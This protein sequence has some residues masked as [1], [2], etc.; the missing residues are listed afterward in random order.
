[1]SSRW[2]IRKHPEFVRNLIDCMVWNQGRVKDQRMYSMMVVALE[3]GLGVVKTDSEDIWNMDKT[4]NSIEKKEV[5]T[6]IKKIDDYYAHFL[7]LRKVKEKESAP[8]FP[9]K[10]SV[11]TRAGEEALKVVEK[12]VV[13]HYYSGDIRRLI[14]KYAP[15]YKKFAEDKNDSVEVALE[16][17]DA[18]EKGLLKN[19]PIGD[20]VSELMH[21]NIV[22][23]YPGGIV[24]KLAFIISVFGEDSDKKLDAVRYKPLDI[25]HDDKVEKAKKLLEENILNSAELIGLCDR[26]DVFL[27]WDNEKKEY[28]VKHKKRKGEESGAESRDGD[29]ELD[30]SKFEKREAP[31]RTD[32]RKVVLRKWAAVILDID[33][34]LNQTTLD[35][36]VYSYMG[37]SR[38]GDVIEV[39]DTVYIKTKEDITSGPKQDCIYKYG[40]FTKNY[41][42]GYVKIHKMADIGGKL[43]FVGEKTDGGNELVFDGK[44]VQTD[45]SIKNVSI[46]DIKEISGKLSYVLSEKKGEK[47]SEALCFGGLDQVFKL[48]VYESIKSPISYQGGYACIGTRKKPEPSSLKRVF[49][50]DV[51]VVNGEEQTLP[52]YVEE[53]IQLFDVGGELQILIRDTAGGYYFMTKEGHKRSDVCENLSNV[54]VVGGKLAYFVID[55]Q[56]DEIFMVW[57]DRRR[58]LNPSEGYSQV[59]N[60]NNKPYFETYDADQKCYFLLDF[61]ETKARFD[62][63]VNIETSEDTIFIGGMQGGKY[64]YYTHKQEKGEN[65]K[66]KEKKQKIDWEKIEKQNNTFLKSTYLT[67]WS[68]NETTQG[69]LPD[70]TP[71]LIPQSNLTFSDKLDTNKAEFGKYTL[72]EDT[73]SLNLESLTK[74]ELE[75]KTTFADIPQSFNGKPLHEVFDYVLKTYGN[76]HYIPG[77]EYWK[78]LSENP[79]KTPEKLKNTSE[80]VYFPGSA[81]RHSSGLWSV[82]SGHWYSAKLCRNGGWLGGAWD[83]ADRVA[84]LEKLPVD[85]R[86]ID[87]QLDTDSLNT[88]GEVEDI[89]DKVRQERSYELSLMNAI[90]HPTQDRLD[91]IFPLDKKEPFTSKTKRF[92][93]HSKKV[94]ST[95][96]DLFKTHPKHFFDTVSATKDE[97]ADWY[98]RKVLYSL[99]PEIAEHKRREEMMLG[100]GSFGADSFTSANAE[101]YLQKMQGEGVEDG[102]PGDEGNDKEVLRLREGAN[103]MIATG[104]YCKWN[105]GS[106]KWEELQFPVS[107]NL[108]EP[109]KD[110]TFELPSVSGL[111]RIN[112]PKLL[113]SEIIRNRVH[114]ITKSGKEVELETEMNNLGQIVALAFN[115]P[116]KLSKI[117]Y[118]QR[119][120]EIPAVPEDVSD[121]NFD[122]FKKKFEKDYGGGAI[123]EIARLSPELEMFVASLEDQNPKEKLIAIESYVR[124]IG[125][126]DF[127]NKEAMKDKR[128]AEGLEERFSIME[129]R[130][131][132][133]KERKPELARELSGKKYAG[134]CADFAVLT[135]ALMRRAGL[136]SGYLTGFRANGEVVTTR[137]AHGTAFAIWPKQTGGYEIISVDGTPGGVTAE[138]KNALEA[139]QQP[140]LEEKEKLAEQKKGEYIEEVE[141]R[142]E[143]VKEMLESN[144]IEKIKSLT[145]GELETLLNAVLKF[146][147]K[148]SHLNVLDGVLNASRYGRVKLPL[149]K[150]IGEEVD[151]RKYVES[152]IKNS[153]KN[154]G[155]EDLV[156]IPAGDKMMT[157]IKEFASRYEKDAKS[158]VETFDVLERI[159]ELSSNAL[160]DVEKKSAMLVVAY[161]RAKKMVK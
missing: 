47:K 115:L 105:K 152:E 149:K 77:I 66:V 88:E 128:K 7:P 91:G 130:M 67:N 44:V 98:V 141:K 100:R 68:H 89:T 118:S 39:G 129:A 27:E 82:P 21:G 146:Q 96:G 103:E 62:S 33:G 131:R 43:A 1:M 92:L 61:T 151:F 157:L 95:I 111:E 19:K 49:S 59:F 64:T 133:I 28:R 83:A 158:K 31:I 29:F 135:T 121:K 13:P 5:K 113:G 51:L 40:N 97:T 80:Y 71:T 14:C 36:G 140:S 4:I 143:E 2:F 48:R 32:V 84:L 50:N 127:G 90:E 93:S 106:K 108:D 137:N 46:K 52:Y 6:L 79:D 144:D 17:K 58:V 123:E 109:V 69:K 139:I 16:K 42:E 24:D 76:T 45:Y 126:Y 156:K 119:R 86:P 35:S 94:A 11:A 142:F 153:R 101:D 54:K 132:D 25:I 147:V 74:E 55:Q 114:G 116:E 102:D 110:M 87:A 159:I 154:S 107:P 41:A 155:G 150:D 120:S 3:Q 72:N 56:S 125:Y 148:E 60:I 23:R 57:G 9:G 26:E 34:G 37:L 99:F 75:A 12:A 18:M 63:P 8:L 117:V 134:V 104:I 81:L 145:N 112:L 65:E 78:L 22:R 30:I 15:E 122:Q 138:E 160:T 70:F 73:Q 20:E 136:P 161:L 53:A 38:D 124:S 10:H 85:Y